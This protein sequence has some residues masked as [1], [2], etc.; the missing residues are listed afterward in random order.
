MVIISTV[1]VNS[2][3]MHYLFIVCK[4]AYMPCPTCKI[5]GQL[6]GIGS[7]LP[8]LGPAG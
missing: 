3:H 4:C 5:R 6:V 1:A 2:G 8:H 7:L